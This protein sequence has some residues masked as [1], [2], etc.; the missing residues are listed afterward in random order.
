MTATVGTGDAPA[1]PRGSPASFAA[2][3]QAVCDAVTAVASLVSSQVSWQRS[4]TEV[5]HG[6]R[7]VHVLRSTVEALHLDLVRALDGRSL[8]TAS[9]VATS[10]E[11]F[12]RATCLVGAGQARRDVAAARAT[13]PG[14]PLA[15]LALELAAGRQTRAHVDVAVRVLDRIPAG[16]LARPGAAARVV[17]YL[18]LAA[19][20]ATPLDMDRAAR[21]LL[22]RTGWVEVGAAVRFDPD[23]HTRRFLDV[24]TDSTGMVVGSFQLDAV[25]GAT[26]RSA[27]DA[28]SAPEP[29]ADGSP[30]RR[31]ARQRR[32]DALVRVAEAALGVGVPRRGERPRVVVHVTP[33]QL[34]DARP[35]V[36][37]A[38]LEDGEPV[39]TGTARRLAC[40]AVLQR[41]VSTPSLGPLDVGRE[42]RLVTLAQRR[43]LAAR[44]GGCV[45]PGCGASPGWCD[46]HHVVHWADGGRSDLSTYV[47]LCPGHHTAVHAGSWEV[48]LV[49][50]QVM[51]T[52]PRWVDPTRTPRPARHQRIERVLHDVDGAA[53]EGRDA[54]AR[55]DAVQRLLLADELSPRRRNGKSA[56]SS[57]PPGSAR[58]APVSRPA[59]APCRP[60]ATAPQ[61]SRAGVPSTPDGGAGPHVPP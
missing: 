59:A 18:R 40:D 34:L 29:G 1:V 57:A 4:D 2:S 38:R 43:A 12:L 21:Q 52:P 30:D 39:S 60:L 55:D 24:H 25:S 28:A 19:A 14:Q 9:P 11:G 48:T 42:H 15:P 3:L 13:A 33:E 61:A 6:V 7:Q 23:G 8:A 32:A 16:T 58:P 20:D 51:V 36:G 56:A 49:H 22:E 53:C 35:G 46:A 50:G 10:P 44:D 31:Q 47:S 27:L 17:D 37:P 45:V 41:V 26:V 5:L 54:P